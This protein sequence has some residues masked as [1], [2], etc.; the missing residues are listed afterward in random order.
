MQY[1]ELI[2]CEVTLIKIKLQ[3]EDHLLG[4]IRDMREFYKTREREKEYYQAQCDMMQESVRQVKAIRHDMKA[5]IA[6]AMRLN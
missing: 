5:Q 6:A 2:P 1:G 3:T 4:F